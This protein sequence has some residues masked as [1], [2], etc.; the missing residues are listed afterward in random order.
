MLELDFEVAEAAPVRFAAA[1]TLAFT[2]RVDAHGP[3][4]RVDAIALRC[5]LRIE[6][7]RRSYAPAEQ[8][9]LRDLFGEVSRWSQTVRSLLWTH[10]STVVPAFTGSTSTELQVPC[11]FDVSLA[12]NRY[13]DALATGEVPLT[14]LFSG[15]VFYAQ[16]DADGRLQA[17][18]IPWDREAS[19]RLPVAVWRDLMEQY[20]PGTVWLG[21]ERD[22]FD[23]LSAYKTER[24]YPSLER[25][26]D[27][28]LARAHEDAPA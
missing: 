28:L 26:L 13:L 11:S 5:Q 19:F 23:R 10:I 12:V 27:D 24:G 4:V 14:F 7:T 9:K 3:D 20:Y 16:A 22:T 8:P 25:A 15:T 21:L 2:V 1:P 17:M 18:P 6:A